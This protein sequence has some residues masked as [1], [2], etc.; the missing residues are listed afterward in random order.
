MFHSS[1]PIRPRT[2]LNLILNLL[3]PQKKH[4]NSD[5]GTSLGLCIKHGLGIK[6]GRRTMHI[7]T[8]L[9]RKN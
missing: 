7:K 3:S 2:R 4:L 8:A 1:L 6:R 9:E 5:W